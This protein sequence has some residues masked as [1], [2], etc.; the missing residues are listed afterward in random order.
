MDTFFRG[1][2]EESR[3]DFSEISERL[4]LSRRDWLP[5][6]FP[7]GKVRANVFYLGNADGGPGE[8]LPIP[9][10]G[11]KAGALIDFAGDFRG[12][13]LD[14]FARGTRQALA[15]AAR[16]A[17]ARFELRPRGKP[18]GTATFP[19][20]HPMVKKADA[21]WTYADAAG[22]LILI[23][24][25]INE[26]DG[27]GNLVRDARGKIKKSF[28]PLICRDGKWVSTWPEVR[29]LYGL[30]DLA[31]RLDA[32]VLVVEGEKTADAARQLFPDM[33]VVTWP[34]GSGG[35]ARVDWSHVCRS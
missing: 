34:Q 10:D 27:A 23:H 6:V 18:S 22:N 13:D 17:A 12:D 8:S 5:K 20:W 31:S 15:E 9:L 7:Q 4:R 26:R 35:T 24:L 25:R 2:A 21:V 1:A 16:D 3:L 30:P 33:M 32:N 29:P 28:R 14:L 11:S 19:D